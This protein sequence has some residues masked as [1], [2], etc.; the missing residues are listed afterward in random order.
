M[1]TRSKASLVCAFLVSAVGLAAAATTSWRPGAHCQPNPGVTSYGVSIGG[2][3]VANAGMNV[4]CH[5]EQA[6]S[7][8]SGTSYPSLAYS[9]LTV[10]L[11]DSKTN[12]DIAC[13]PV[14]TDWTGTLY[15]GAIRFQE[16]HITLPRLGCFA[17]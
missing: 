8:T 1:T 14:F 4:Y 9:G 6:T 12:A 11:N 16:P 15:S 7:A 13:Y 5:N 3:F 17:F 2:V 10:Q